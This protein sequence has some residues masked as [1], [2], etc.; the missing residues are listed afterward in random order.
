MQRLLIIRLMVWIYMKLDSIK[1]DD[2]I[3]S[4]DNFG[5]SSYVP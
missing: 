2:D 1:W 3:I 4:N 5:N